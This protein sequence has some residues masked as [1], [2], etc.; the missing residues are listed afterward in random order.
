MRRLKGRPPVS[1]LFGVKGRQWLR[2]LVFPVEEQETV[3]GCPR[4]IEFLDREIAEVE[5]P[6]ATEALDSAE[7]RRLMTVPGVNV[8]AAATFMA[9]VGDIHRFATQRQL[10]GY[11]GLDPNHRRLAGV[12]LEDR[13]YRSRI[14]ESCGWHSGQLA[15]DGLLQA[16]AA[17]VLLGSRMF[18]ARLVNRFAD[19]IENLTGVAPMTFRDWCERHVDE[20]AARDAKVTSHIA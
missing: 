18:R 6:I 17:A 14:T 15:D 19:D 9:A 8:I 16:S 10:V 1:D 5:R 13:R 3:D 12:A 11:L 20:F 2:G 7:I 4:H